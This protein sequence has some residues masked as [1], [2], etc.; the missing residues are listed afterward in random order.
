MPRF[1]WD[2]DPEVEALVEETNSADLQ[3]TAVAAVM[4]LP[5]VAAVMQLPA[6]AAVMQQVAVA[7]AEAR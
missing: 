1:G 4:Q 5:A 2:V 3:Q 6:V 7:S